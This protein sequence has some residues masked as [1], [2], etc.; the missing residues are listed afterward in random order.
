MN[1]TLRDVTSESCKGASHLYSLIKCLGCATLE[2]D[3]I[4]ADTCGR[5]R[6]LLTVLL[7]VD[8]DVRLSISS[9]R[10]WMNPSLRLPI[11]LSVLSFDIILS[12]DHLERKIT[13]LIYLS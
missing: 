3:L 2:D 4:P 6:S 5:L 13:E 12:Y 10:S 8:G 9:W 11:T 1:M 7:H